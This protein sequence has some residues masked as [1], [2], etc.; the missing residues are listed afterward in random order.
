MKI[1]IHILFLALLCGCM[2]DEKKAAASLQPKTSI[3]NSTPEIFLGGGRNLQLVNTATSI[4]V[5]R[6]IDSEQ[7]P[8]G[9]TGTIDGFKCNPT[10]SLVSGPEVTQVI[11][12]L[13]KTTN[14]GEGLMCIFEPGVILRFSSGRHTL[15]LIVCFHCREMVLYSDGNVVR[16]P[17]MWASIKNTFHKEAF[18][19]F[20][21]IAKKAFP[22]D[23]EI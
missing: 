3:T 7:K 13:S 19:A 1:C 14:F 15:D 20:V 21:A 17:Y 11:D 5:F 9:T 10:P 16:R 23:T 4:T 8:G 12:A 22:N 6:I 18:Q 2:T